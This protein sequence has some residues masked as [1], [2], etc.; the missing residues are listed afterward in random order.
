MPPTWPPPHIRPPRPVHPFAPLEVSLIKVKAR[1]NG[2]VAVTEIE[3]EFYNPNNARIEGTFVFPIP[4]GAHLD[5][6]TMEID[7]KQVEAELLAADKARR[8]Y[9]DIV[10]N[11]RDP[12]LLEYA[13]R[14]IFKARIFP[15]EPRSK[16]RI[17]LSYTQVLKADDGLLAFNLPLST[18]KF[19][20]KPVK[21]VSVRIDLEASAALKS[22]YSPTHQVE[23]RRDGA[24]RASVRYEGGDANE[25]RPD[26]DF[27]LYFAPEKDEIGAHLLT[28]RKGE[29]DG[30]FLLL[31]S[32]GLDVRQEQVV[33]K[34]VVFVLDTSGSMAGKKIEQAK[35]ALAFC[36]ESLNS[37]D[38]F[39]VMR[40]STE[41]ETL[42]DK[43]V[44]PSKANR[45]KADE[46]R[47]EPQ[48]DGRH[49]H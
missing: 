36:V 11:L 2:Q 21:D 28:F 5:K 49:R 10:R 37:G 17:T 34:D 16:K 4:K 44:E 22:I 40:F 26:S 20:A 43:L 32:P 45:T 24:R 15:I 18:E 30:Y 29:E 1:I 31:A 33:Q 3:Q 14:D 38:R 23:I 13:G 27:A 25:N 39:E 6:F 7:G 12:A 9:E 47:E 19:S 8:I 41:V 48:G 35:K 46:L 42:F